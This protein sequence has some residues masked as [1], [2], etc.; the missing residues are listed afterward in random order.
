M[1]CQFLQL[2]IAPLVWQ[3]KCELTANEH[4]MYIRFLWPHG[5]Q[6]RSI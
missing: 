6:Y 4:F 5:P 3:P 1:E 2:I